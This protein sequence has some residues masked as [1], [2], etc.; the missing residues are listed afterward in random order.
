MR[1]FSLLALNFPHLG[2][3]IVILI[4]GLLVF[5]KRLPEV[6]RSI[7][8]SIVEFKKGLRGVQNEIESAA[9]EPEKPAAPPRPPL[10]SSQ[11]A[12]PALPGPGAPPAGTQPASEPRP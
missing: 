10:P 12:A 4:V 8:R 3:T 6:A 2:E 5:G 9:D 7:G 1:P 11:A